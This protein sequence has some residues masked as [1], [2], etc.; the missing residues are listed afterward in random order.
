MYVLSLLKSNRVFCPTL[1]AKKVDNVVCIPL[2]QNKTH[3]QIVFYDEA[4]K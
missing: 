3:Y 1:F 4:H 2:S